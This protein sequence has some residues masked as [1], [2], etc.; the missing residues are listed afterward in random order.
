MR[1][2]AGRT[3]ASISFA[4]P[5]FVTRAASTFGEFETPTAITNVTV[6]TEPGV[7]LEGAAIVI[8][9]GR[10]AAVGTNVDIPPH[11][12]RI[13]A[14]GLTAYP[15]F[16]DASVHLGIPEKVR[17]ETQR[18]R[19]EDFNPDPREGAEFETRFAGRRGI[20]PQF[21]VLHLF[22]PDEKA[23]S[24]HR[25][26]GFTA[27]LVTPRDGIFSGASD[28]FFLSGDPIRRAAF[29]PSVAMHTS[30]TTGEEGEYPRTLLGVFAQF[31]QVLLDARWYAKWQK[32]A[33]R[34]PTS[35]Q[36][37]PTDEALAALQPILA[38]EQ[39]VIFEANSDLE[40][41][42]ALD[43]CKEFNLNV[44]I[45]GAREA[46]KVLDRL[47]ADRVP[48]IV[49][50]KF[51]EEP[52]YGKKKGKS[53]PRGKPDA[54]LQS[55]GET[56][57]ES[58]TPPDEA[59]E[60]EKKDEKKE[61]EKRIYEPLKVRQ[62]QRRLW[63][64]HAANIIRLHE[65]GVPF[66]LSTRD[67]E[68]PSEF[69]KNLR[70][71][72]ERGL[73]EDAALA[74][75]TVNPAD[76]LKAGEQLGRV[77]PGQVANLTLMDKPLSDKKAKVKF[78][79]IDGKKFKIEEE[80][81]EGEVGM[82]RFAR[83][84]RGEEPEKEE[85]QEEESE[86]PSTEAAAAPDEKVEMDKGPT[87]ASEIEADRVPQ[88]RTGGNV[89]IQNATII[90]VSS[91]TLENA[92]ILIRNGKIEALG[93]IPNVPAGVTIIDGTGK[94]VIPGFVDCHSHLGLDGVNESANAISAEV[95]IADVIDPHSVGIYRA[96][97]GG[98]TTHHAMHG[99]ANPIGG[100]NVILK[101]K[102]GRPASDMILRDAPPTIKF[103]LGENV[104]QTNFQPNWG[105]RFPNTRMGVEAVMRAAL[106]GGKRYQHEWDGYERRAKT[107]EDLLP[108]RHDLRLQSLSD[109]LAGKLTVHSHCYRSDEILR[110]LAV[111]EDYGFRIGTLQHV[112]EGYRIAPE[113]ARH[114]AGASTF[115][116]FWAY[117]V[118][119]Y[120]AI[121][122]NAALMTENGINVSVNSDSP[123]TIRFFGLEAAK[124][125][126]WGGLDEVEALKLVTLNPA[127][128]LQIDNHVGALEAGKDG[129]IAI[130]NGHPLN[131]FARC[132][133]TLIDGEVY[134]ED[135]DATPVEPCAT[136]NPP[137]DLDRTIPQTPHRAYAIVNAIIHPISGPVMA[138]ATVVIVEDKIHALG[139]DAQV[140]PG[141]GVINGQGLHVYPGLIDAGSTL[142]LFEV[143][144]LRATLDSTDIATFMPHLKTASAIH[145]H[146]EHIRITRTVGTTTAMVKPTG[147]G[148]FRREQPPTWILGQSAVMHLNGWT[149][150]EM[151]LTDSF[152]LHLRVP[153]LPETL[154]GDKKEQERQKKEHK[155]AMKALEEFFAK[156][157][158][159][160][161]AKEAQADNP[162]IDI[163]T[164]IPLEA[165]IPFVRGDRRIILEASAYKQIED[166][167]DF[168][169]KHELKCILYG[170]TES[171]K[172]AD[173][174]AQKNIPVIL[175]GPLSYPRGEFELWDSIY[176]CAAKLDKAGVKFCFAS[177]DSAEA[178]N[179]P[180]MAGM[181]VAHGLPRERA[182][183]ALT[184]GAAEILGLADRIGSIEPGKI[185]DLIVTTDTPLQTVSQVTHMFIAGEPVT[186]TSMH[187]EEYE[188]FKN[189]PQ[190]KLPP[191][192]VLK[193]P[194]DLS[195]PAS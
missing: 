189:R 162:Q 56:E 2:I 26:A 187:T 157:K 112:L 145:P 183:Y 154:R 178:F 141:A 32:F 64:E 70:L 116:N 117:K 149:A 191:K 33:E 74:A 173:K 40:I 126:K 119:A 12:E 181:A 131:S 99:S 45:S 147:G 52:E 90:P 97:A 89:L 158:H 146:S 79:F 58:Q 132:V 46:Y 130:F 180:I 175:A 47:K 151:L 65:A 129:D 8:D 77:R 169:E 161:K 188:K 69:L 136:L 35:S 67:F 82:G 172:L 76:L 140:P 17:D 148:G 133:M 48:L 7:K 150:N 39:R 176:A 4:L 138:N 184:L 160:A 94:F 124:C 68:K 105:K 142:G 13:D 73:P 195:K 137:G 29:L 1:P 81:K 104:T 135:D 190:P 107:G 168:A 174:L 91:P 121:P 170:A 88:T 34:H 123:N 42:R 60:G 103:A 179:L 125:I 113:I 50:L 84:R 167:L 93:Q 159:Y 57:K 49:S 139:S 100:Q 63:E 28:V 120:G 122:H 10:I 177:D 106:E 22:A 115:S 182:E 110:L 143:G 15:G 95:R 37:S 165:M 55:E 36:R 61:K 114:G 102:Y 118:E 98:T 186:L 71:V 192:P 3:L 194:P 20:R 86:E 6:V 156:A 23:L 51:E 75:L 193:G 18:I 62:E 108:P 16:V 83:G 111:A 155:E 59:V 30:F 44:V 109:V 152:G 41:L 163:E 9:E 78:V 14:T 31:R 96:V 27:A 43:L 92:S 144:S 101:L 38:R 166:A 72:I 164:D 11:A 85:A 171:W 128:Q 54:K 80:E 25:A 87:F 19:T 66:A 153:S 53:P 185:A 21:R 24:A 127:M 134:F 5:I